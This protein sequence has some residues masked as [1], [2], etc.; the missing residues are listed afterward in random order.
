[1]ARYSGDEPIRK[2]V[3]ASLILAAIF[4]LLLFVQHVFNNELAILYEEIGP[5]TK[6]GFS[7]VSSVIYLAIYLLL[8]IL[9]Y[10]GLRDDMNDPLMYSIIIFVVALIPAFICCNVASLEGLHNSPNIRVRILLAAPVGTLFASPLFLAFSAI[11]SR[12]YH[13]EPRAFPFILWFP[14]LSLFIGYI[15]AFALSFIP[16]YLV[17]LNVYCISSSALFIASAIFLSLSHPLGETLGFAIDFIETYHDY[18]SS[19]SGGSSSSSYSSHSGTVPDYVLDDIAR[20]VKD[21]SLPILSQAIMDGVSVRQSGSTLL[22][23]VYLKFSFSESYSEYDAKRV[24]ERESDEITGRAAS[25][26]E[27]RLSYHDIDFIN[28]ISADSEADYSYYD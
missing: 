22:I 11:L 24:V 12:R 23:T 10:A 21:E 2:P 17:F 13:D 20:H 9:M 6:L 28:D 4:A 7:Y 8:A 25:I 3:I 14:L 1:M 15:G 27:E 16:K 5:L 19:N 18:S 26:A